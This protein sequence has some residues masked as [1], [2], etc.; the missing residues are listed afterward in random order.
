MD[1]LRV[2]E[3][4]TLLDP[5]PGMRSWFGGATPLGSLR[6][7]SPKEAAWKPSPKRH[8]IWE[9]TLHIAYWKYAVRRVL[10]SLPAGGFPRSPANWPKVGVVADLRAWTQ[11]RGVLRSEQQALVA[12]IRKI[13]PQRLDQK[14]KEHGAYRYI[15]LLFGVVQH[16]TYHTA[17]IQL[18]KR[19]YRDSQ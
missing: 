10:D 14:T 7:V 6:G 5:K 4:L 1:D 12:S 13:D 9:L 17:Q 3:V 19:L 8:S 2:Q 15:D 16:D 11:T 18:L